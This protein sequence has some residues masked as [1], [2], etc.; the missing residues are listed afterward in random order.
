MHKLVRPPNK[1]KFKYTS[2]LKSARARARLN[3]QTN[4]D[5][6]G[7][8]DQLLL[9]FTGT[10]REVAKNERERELL[11]D[12]ITVSAGRNP[13]A[14][15][16]QWIRGKHAAG[17]ILSCGTVQPGSVLSSLHHPAQ[18]NRNILLLRVCSFI[19]QFL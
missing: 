15:S 8:C 1:C 7:P 11:N 16:G 14:I 3:T 5:A 10:K 6:S 4:M 18:C 13:A 12:L 17:N 2:F 19:A 9:I